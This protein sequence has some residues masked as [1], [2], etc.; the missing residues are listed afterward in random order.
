MRS[1]LR[2]AQCGEDGS[3]SEHTRHLPEAGQEG[4]EEGSGPSETGPWVAVRA[5]LVPLFPPPSLP[6]SN[7]Y[8]LLRGCEWQLLGSGSTPVP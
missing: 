8:T 4:Q 6:P 3:E 1:R 7:L 5:R 2:G